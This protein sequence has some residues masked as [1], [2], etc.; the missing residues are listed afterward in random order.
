[1]R[2]RNKLLRMTQASIM[3]AL[4]LLFVQCGPSLNKAQDLID[5]GDEEGAIKMLTELAEKGDN[6]AIEW[7]S[8]IYIEKMLWNTDSLTTPNMKAAEPWLISVAEKPE[9]DQFS[10]ALLYKIYISDSP[11]KDQAK[12]AKWSIVAAEKG[13]TTLMSVAG[14]YLLEKEDY[15]TAIKYLE[16]C[17]NRK[18]AR[19]AVSLD[20]ASVR[21][22]SFDLYKIY[23][24]S[25]IK[26]NNVEKALKYGDKAAK[27]GHE[28]AANLMAM[29][30]FY[31][32]D[33][34]QNIDKAME[35]AGY[36][37]NIFDTSIAKAKQADEK[38]KE[39]KRAMAELNR[40]NDIL[41]NSN[42]IK[43]E[44]SGVSYRIRFCSNMTLIFERND[45]YDK[46]SN[47]SVKFKYSLNK[48]FADTLT[49]VLTFN[50]YIDYDGVSPDWILDNFNG[51]EAGIAF[52]CSGETMKVVGNRI[53]S[54][55]YTQQ[56]R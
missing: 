40:I 9:S 42:W 12:A 6:E 53:M 16:T 13:D 2:L 43:K 27:L 21:E 31:G 47:Y 48:D 10:A 7:L 8:R 28:K 17:A 39:A 14:H 49:P 45:L 34:S 22:A 54:G 33:V 30:Y 46:A 11:L 20:R 1:M 29:H 38:M 15:T 56:I 37:S 51:E 41:N 50:K 32:I 55:N 24:D 5:A 3:T 25:T 36:T 19:D 52:T 23:M 35:Y 4:V 44:S 26:Y 18:L